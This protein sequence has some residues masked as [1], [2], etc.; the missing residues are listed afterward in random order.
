MFDWS[1]IHAEAMCRSVELR[2]QKWLIKQREMELIASKN[3]LLPRLDVGGKYRWLGVGQDL[4]QQPGVAYNPSTGQAIN[5]TDAF[6]TLAAGD[7]QEWELGLNFSMPI[8]FRQPLA[9]VRNAQLNLAHDRTIL[10][11]QELEVSHQL[12]D[13][14]RDVDT[15]YVLAQTNFNRFEA[16]EKQVK[17]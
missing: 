6:S 14:I 15:D 5:G 16:A 17:R 8:G 2:K 13:V 10:Q 12:A 9:A 11:D 1:E 7:F 3:L 4:V